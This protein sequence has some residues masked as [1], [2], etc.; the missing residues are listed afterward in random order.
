ML[1]EI[2]RLARRQ[3][4]FWVIPVSAYIEQRVSWLKA[5]ADRN[6]VVVWCFETVVWSA[7]VE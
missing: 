7:P 5:F 6:S 2:Y 4:S 1:S 3:C